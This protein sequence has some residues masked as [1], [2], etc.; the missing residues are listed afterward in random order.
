MDQKIRKI[1][2][3]YV[4]LHPRSNVEQLYLPRC[5]GCRGLVSIEDCVNGERKNLAPYALK[6]NEK[7]IIAATAELKLKKFINVQNR[8][9]RRKQRLNDW[10]EKALHGQL[11]RKTESTNDVN[12]WE[13]LKRGELKRETNHFVFSSRTVSAS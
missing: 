8:K 1:I 7:L 12:R 5:E 3:M 2:T 4:G 10:K 6:S 13:W 11:L 9:E